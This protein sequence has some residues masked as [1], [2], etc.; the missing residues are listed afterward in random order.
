MRVLSRSIDAGGGNTVE[1]L[2]VPNDFGSLLQGA[3]SAVCEDSVSGRFE[4]ALAIRARPRS[5]FTI[6]PFWFATNRKTSC[7]SGFN[8]GVVG[9]RSQRH[10][11]GINGLHVAE[12]PFVMPQILF[13][14]SAPGCRLLNSC[15]VDAL[16]AGSPTST[17]H[18]FGADVFDALQ[19]LL[20]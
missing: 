2:S 13:E 10:P 9:C 19:L 12:G 18:Y 7:T 8:V 1:M 14:P 11:S 4:R 3:G 16:K 15:G 17:D 5:E 6:A 20:L